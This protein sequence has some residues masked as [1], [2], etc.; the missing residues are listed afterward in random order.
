[1]NFIDIFAGIGGFRAG[2]EKAGHKCVGYI[3]KDT[4]ARK[5]Y[6]AIFQTENEWTS[7]DITKVNPN[8]IPKAEIWCF[9]FPCQDVSI[10][11]Q[12]KGLKG[13]RSGLFYTVM[14]LISAQTEENKPLILLIENV[15]NLLSVNEGWD[16]ASLL[17]EL[18]KAGYDTEWEVLNSENFGVPQRRKRVFIVGSLRGKK[19]LQIFPLT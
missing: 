11:G 9:G 19:D 12:K 8:E 10:S 7:E 18:D 2:L 5:S 16:F 1:M 17:C 6:E 13:E 15:A 14:D 4:N 3:E